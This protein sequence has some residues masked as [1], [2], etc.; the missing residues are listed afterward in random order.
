MDDAQRFVAAARTDGQ[1][2][3][4]LIR[5]FYEGQPDRDLFIDGGAHHGY[6]TS[7]ARQFF[8]RVVSVEASPRTYV[9]HVTGQIA[10]AGQ[11]AA[12]GDLIPVNAALGCRAEQGK[13]VD[14]FFSE[15]HPGRSTV[16][17]ALWDAW[18]KGDVVYQAPVTAAVIEVDD[19]R[20][21]HGRGR[22]VDFIKLDLEGGEINAL[23]GARATLAADQ[24]AIVMEF[25]MKPDNEALYGETCAGFVADMTAQGY[26]LYTPWA[27]R[28][29]AL[30]PT[31]YPFWYLFC[32]PEGPRGASLADRLAACFAHSL[33]EPGA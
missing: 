4:R 33:Q 32:L 6:H 25:G 29:E 11:N 27:A 22:R 15:T 17:T 2:I 14:F 18:A 21:L 3:E 1:K 23:R 31:G 9:E 7:H 16:N 12:L 8:A 10:R 24:P 30:I 26:G 20:A 13:T 28:A 5:L 19:L